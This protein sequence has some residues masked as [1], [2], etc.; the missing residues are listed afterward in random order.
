MPPKKSLIDF[1]NPKDVSIV[2][3]ELVKNNKNMKVLKENRLKL[4]DVPKDE[5]K[6]LREIKNY[7]DSVIGLTKAVQTVQEPELTENEQLEKD[8]MSVPPPPLHSKKNKNVNWTRK[9]VMDYY[10]KFK[11]DGITLSDAWGHFRR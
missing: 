3:D 1:S 8:I 7:L 11:K 2:I 6:K 4:S 10:N 5:L 9:D